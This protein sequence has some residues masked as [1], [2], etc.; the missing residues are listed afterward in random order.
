MGGMSAP[1]D[2]YIYL[3]PCYD[4]QSEREFPILYMLHGKDYSKEQWV[5]L[6]LITKTNELIASGQIPPLIIVLPEDVGY[7]YPDE[8]FFEDDL[9]NDVIPYLEEN[10]QVKEGREYRAL[11]G[12]SRGAGWTMYIG[13]NHPEMFS[14]LGMHSLAIFNSLEE[15]EYQEWMDAISL[16]DMPRMYLD[17]GDEE[18]ELLKNSTNA[19]MEELDTRDFEYEFY[20]FLGGHDEVYWSSYVDRYL[21]FYVEGWE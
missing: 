16:D 7:E 17:Y 8:D 1:M 18:F 20:E 11:G 15:G 10:Y 2:F 13:L 5:R 12:L 4:Q 6:G 19:F 21:L 3:P 14:S 9:L